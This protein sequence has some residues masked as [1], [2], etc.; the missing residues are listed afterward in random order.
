[1]ASLT[2]AVAVTV[3]RFQGLRSCSSPAK[4]AAA[5]AP[6]RLAASA[7]GVRASLKEVGV[8]LAA[9][10]ASAL[11][12]SGAL[13]FDVKLGN[14]TGALEFVP[15][16]FSVASGE[17]I[18]FINNTGFPHNVVFDPDDIPRGST[19]RRSPWMRSVVL[20][21]PGSYRFYCS[22]H[23]GAGMVGNVVVK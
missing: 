10:A 7:V 22:P 4:V 15:K 3:P 13:A 6:A 20:K 14:D 18:V 12:A 5:V 9:T 17:E 19:R 2:A 23:L 21:I 16:D 1:M 11:L 8:A